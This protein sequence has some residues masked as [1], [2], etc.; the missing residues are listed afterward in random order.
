MVVP[1]V[2][3]F[4]DLDDVNDKS[5]KGKGQNGMSIVSASNGDLEMDTIGDS[6]HAY[7]STYSSRSP[8]N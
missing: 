1:V 4:I 8:G 5:Q 3:L 7:K 6:I 2:V